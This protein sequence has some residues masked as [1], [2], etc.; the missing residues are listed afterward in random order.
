M[1]GQGR[2]WRGRW[3]A[4]ETQEVGQVRIKVVLVGLRSR[5]N[6]ELLMQWMLRGVLLST[7]SSQTN[8]RV[9]SMPPPRLSD[10]PSRSP[11]PRPLRRSWLRRL[12]KIPA[13]PCRG[14]IK[15]N[16]KAASNAEATGPFL[17]P[18][19]SDNRMNTSPHLFSRTHL[20][21]WHTPS[22]AI[23][24]LLPNFKKKMK[25]FTNLP[26]FYLPLRHIT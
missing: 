23:V 20:P 9:P 8:L 2:R 11:K 6:L 17:F 12:S 24:S 4:A 21:E 13:E 19:E 3:S 7:Y 18:C 15:F 10:Q 22:Y 14:N 25:G 16:M 5:I 1:M 26:N